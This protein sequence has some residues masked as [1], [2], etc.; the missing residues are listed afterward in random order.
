M[1]TKNAIKKPIKPVPMRKRLTRSQ[2]YIFTAAQNA[3]P[4]HSNFWNNLLIA[5]K[6]FSAGFHVISGRYKNPT[7]QWTEANL[8][9]EW[10]AEE[11]LPY[12]FNGR[13]NL[14]RRI[15]VLG[16]AKI[17]WSASSPLARFDS[18]TKDRSGIVGH[19]NR[20]LRSIATPQHKHPKI[21]FT[22]GS[23]TVDGNY[24]DSGN[25]I[26]GNFNHCLGA[27]IVE[28]DGDVFYP[29]QIN[30]DDEG[31]FIDLDVEFY[32]GKVRQAK[33]ALSISMGDTHQRFILPEVVKATF[34]ASDSM[35][36]LLK[37]KHLIWHDLLDQHARNHHHQG[38]WLT[39]YGKWNEGMECVRTEIEEAIHF[40]NTK[41][42]N[43][44]QS[45]VVSSNHDRAID[46]WLKEADFRADPV[47]AKFFLELSLEV[48][49]TVKRYPGGITYDD[50]FV[51]YAK[52]SAANNV[53]FL[54]QGQ[55]FI[56]S[57]VEYGLHGDLGPNGARGTT[58]NLSTIGVKVTKGHNHTA[59]IIN[60]C[61]SAGKS[62]GPLEYEGGGPSSHSNAH[63]VQYAN[64]KRAILFIVKGRYC[65]K[66]RRK[67]T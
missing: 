7:S 48:L 6:Y 38:N 50:P 49:K 67:K 32:N 54:R 21:M 37:P 27:L 33:P 19:G 61:Y 56:L 24:T 59:E 36:K 18:I 23:C 29:R 58:K 8:E 66:R 9:H 46:R 39:A 1:T 63:V 2:T 52:K 13:R 47:N 26:I 43:D 28:I 11:V 40:V 14:N 41:T 22:T 3:T 31:N 44:C 10:W 64:G 16:D 12:L 25:G 60:G 20:A 34:D 45:V 30:A 35:V 4:V 57:G 17:Q 51:L 62:T 15:M 53:Q 65:L 42:P 5:K 55:S